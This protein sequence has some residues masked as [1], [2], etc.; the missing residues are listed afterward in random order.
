MTDMPIIVIPFKQKGKHAYVHEYSSFT[1]TDCT[2]QWF[3]RGS[4]LFTDKMKCQS[5]NWCWRRG[6][7]MHFALACGGFLLHSTPIRTTPPTPNITMKDNFLKWGHW[8]RPKFQSLAGSC[9]ILL[10]ACSP[11]A[12]MNNHGVGFAE[13]QR[14]VNQILGSCC[15]SDTLLRFP[16]QCVALGVNLTQRERTVALEARPPNVCQIPC[17]SL[18]AVL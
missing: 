17:W 7:D 18:R 2:K 14:R 1:E 4:I 11:A 10:L 16:L 8:T 3:V 13:Q 5:Y 6:K 9:S 12:I 15:R